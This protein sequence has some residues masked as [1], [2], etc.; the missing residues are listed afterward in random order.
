MITLYVVDLG[1]K[2]KFEV[3]A[4]SKSS[5][6]KSKSKSF[7]LY[8]KSKSKSNKIGLKSGLEEL[9]DSSHY[10]TAYN[11]TAVRPVTAVFAACD[12]PVLDCRLTGAERIPT[13]RCHPLENWCISSY[14]NFDG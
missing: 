1:S 12:V 4:K 6:A 11:S 3:R 13:Y 7:G 8:A 14:R 10:I 2:S 9:L 5:N